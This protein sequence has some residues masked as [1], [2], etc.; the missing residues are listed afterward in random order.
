MINRLISVVGLGVLISSAAMTQNAPPVQTLPPAV[1]PAPGGAAKIMTTLPADAMS[2]TNFYKQNVYDPVDNKI[3][4]I[5]D[6][7][8]KKDGT[9]AVAMVAVG[10]F[11]GIGEK[12]VAIPFDSMHL[13]DKWDLVL[14]TTKDALKA[15][16][17][18]KYD[19]KRASWV[20]ETS[21]GIVGPGGTSK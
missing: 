6:L 10:G 13:D 19:Q 8:V 15:A 16:P 7:L 21:T 11:L 18:F 20:P 9:I 5:V 14:N 12:D 3:G 2:I 1:Q 4:D 17:G